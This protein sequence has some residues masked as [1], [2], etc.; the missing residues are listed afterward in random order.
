MR[1]TPRH[2]LLPAL[3][4]LSCLPTGC[5]TTLTR[6]SLDRT[7]R[8]ALPALP[9]ALTKTETLR[10]L[11]A[12]PSGELVSIDKGFLGELLDR[13]AEAIAAVGR[14]NS[15]LIAVRQERS[16]ADAILRTG[17]A[18]AGCPSN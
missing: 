1:L 6:P 13:A 18:P 2:R 16:C 14:L 7:D 3:L 15:R 5:A 17:V 12:K 8:A 11:E 10:P 4:L 9:E